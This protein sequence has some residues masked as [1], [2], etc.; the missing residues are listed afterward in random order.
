M[1]ID[2]ALY[3]AFLGEMEALD[4]FRLGY[5]AQHPTAPLEREDPDVR[6]LIEALALFSARTRQGG[7]RA[8]MRGARRLFQQ[9]FPYVASPIPA[10]AMLR[11]EVDG[12]FV[13]V[14][15][16]PGGTEV[17]FT[18]RAEDGGA[19]EVLAF[20][21]QAPLRLVPVR[22]VG[23]DA[24]KRPGGGT[25]LALRLEGQFERSDELGWIDL[26]VNHLDD[27]ASSLTVSFHLRRCLE[28]VRVV[29]DDEKPETE[30]GL[31]AEV[32]FG[33]P[34]RALSPRDH[35]EH[36]LLAVREA[37]HFPQQELF[38]R[39]RPPRPPRNWRAFTLCFDLKPSWP[40]KLRLTADTFVLHAVPLVNRARS[41]SAPIEHD[42]TRER[43][44]IAH[45]EAGLGY[46]AQSVIGAYR[47]A[48]SGLEALR[49]GVLHSGPG[50]YEVE[51]EGQREQRRS[52]LTLEAPGAFSE[53]VRATVDGF[54]FQPAALRRRIDEYRVTLAERH[55][56]GVRWRCLSGGA[57]AAETKLEQ[58]PE[59]LLRL[60]AL[61]SMRFLRLEDLTFLLDV[62][63]PRLAPVFADVLGALESL[64]VGPK[65][66]ARSSSGL[67][68]VYVLTLRD[69]DASLLP[70][71]D[72][73]ARKA[74]EILDAWCAEER[75]ELE[76]VVPNLEY[77]ESYGE[78]TEEESR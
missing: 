17:V 37:L 1:E 10:M 59:A 67:K 12:R 61:K 22:V 7:Q 53:P 44:L 21:A 49:P 71:L 34:P 2:D 36:A 65:P 35:V 28:A 43:H 40:V 8:V 27:L 52:W 19:D 26:L 41:L 29:F 55:V 62:L 30:R 46:R 57:P 58:D 4:K 75:V 24:L 15:E 33:P 68:Y 13:E 50:T 9:H 70:A 20:R 32:R 39:V 73:L 11:A 3:K 23:L 14:T 51:H 31:P 54:W 38:L 47:L 69:L 78:E 16:V 42:G 60:V 48:E 18:A 6:R 76:V 56:A 45:P 74:R 5:L 77:R 64:Q 25:R 63:A 66:A 72:L